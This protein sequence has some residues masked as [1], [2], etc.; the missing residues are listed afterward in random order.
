TR[1]QWAACVT[2]TAWPLP[3]SAKPP[4]RSASSS[5]AT[6]S[7]EPSTPTPTAT[8]ASKSPSRCST[9]ASRLDDGHCEHCAGHCHPNDA[10]RRA[11]SPP[12]HPAC[13]ATQGSRN[14]ERI[15][16]ALRYLLDADTVKSGTPLYQVL[17]ES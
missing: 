6:P 13:A 11:G 3:P 14:L 4:A 1:P 17:I 8:P 5:N 15:A 7:P 2:P 9:L 16:G 12:H 10:H